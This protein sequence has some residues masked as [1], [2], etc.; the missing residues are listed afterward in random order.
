MSIFRLSS[1][2]NDNIRVVL[3]EGDDL[4]R[5]RN[6]LPFQDTS[7]CLVHHFAEDAKCPRES[8][9]KL[10]GREGVFESDTLVVRELGDGGFRVVFH[11]SGIAEE[12]PVSILAYL[13]FLA[14]RIVMTLFFTTLWWSLNW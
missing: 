2:F 14:L 6:L 5:G 13:V 7:F 9:G 8:S 12:I 1:S 11:E 3:K 4:L 10:V